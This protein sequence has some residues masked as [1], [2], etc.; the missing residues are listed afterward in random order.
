MKDFFS[1]GVEYTSNNSREGLV[2]ASLQLRT[3]M[4]KKVT[5]AAQQS[6]C[7]RSGNQVKR[8]IRKLYVATRLHMGRKHPGYRSVA[9]LKYNKV[10]ECSTT[11]MLP[12]GMSFIS[13]SP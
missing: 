8:I 6:Q 12:T 9:Q 11:K 2:S 4:G 1:P 13:I 5:L 10:L 3:Y 7:Q